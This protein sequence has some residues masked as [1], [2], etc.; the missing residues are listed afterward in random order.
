MRLRASTEMRSEKGPV[1]EKNEDSMGV[2]QEPHARPGID[3]V[4]VVADGLGGHE[5][6]EVAS[7]MAID[8]LLRAFLPQEATNEHLSQTDLTSFLADTLVHINQVIYMA[9]LSGEAMHRDP[10]RAG[11]ATT[12]T[13]A[14][15]AEDTIYLG[16]VGDS[17]A[18]LLRSGH[19]FQLTKDHT[20]V[21]DRVRRGLIS[22]EEA[23]HFDRNVITQALGL[24]HPVHPH[25]SSF[26]LEENDRILLCSDGLH[27]FLE[28]KDIAAI[29]KRKDH[30]G[31]VDSLV[32]ESIAAGSTDNITAIL[33]SFDSLVQ[34]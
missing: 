34:G 3:A 10:Y 30:E 4:Y 15:L 27:G 26:A 12:L 32:E 8:L 19:L 1:R 2:L 5:D 33:V 13:A 16:H 7:A 25:T 22:P 23:R 24:D 6:G 14:V 18:Y 21:A 29:M 31:A 11:M 28:D 9:G 17:R 20:Q